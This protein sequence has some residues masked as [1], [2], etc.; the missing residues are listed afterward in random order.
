[1]SYYFHFLRLSSRNQCIVLRGVD[2][3]SSSPVMEVTWTGVLAALLLAAVAAA[4]EADKVEE[5]T[6]VEIKLA[7]QETCKDDLEVLKVTWTES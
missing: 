5:E 3:S 1:M 4:P 6:S 2:N 7:E